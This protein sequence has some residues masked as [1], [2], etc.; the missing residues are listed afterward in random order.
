[1][2]HAS[3]NPVFCV[4]KP[5][6]CPAS[7]PGSRWDAMKADREGWFHSRAEEAAYCPEHVPGWVPAWRA[8]QAARKFRV[9]GTHATLPAVLKCQGCE[10]SE[11]EE[12]DDTHDPEVLIAMRS[13]GF[14]HAKQTGHTVTVGTSQHLVIEPVK[15]S[16]DA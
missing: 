2:S 4:R 14:E 13:R 7:H 9:Q 10:F 8:K 1:M 5:E 15:E 16:A 12:A 11:V 6:G 3:D